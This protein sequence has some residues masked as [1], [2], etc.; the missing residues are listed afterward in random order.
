[1]KRKPSFLIVGAVKGGTTALY[2]YL[3]QHKDIFLPKLKE[4]KFF[5]TPAIDFPQNGIGDHYIDRFRITREDQYL[6]L[7]EGR[8][9][10]LIGEATPEYLYY[11]EKV[12]ESVYEYLGDIKIIISLRNPV[13]RAFSSYTNLVRDRREKLTFRQGLDQE[14][15]RLADNWDMLWAYKRAGLYSEQV[16]SFINRFSKV[17]IVKQ[18]DMFESSL[19]VVRTVL[20]FLEVDDNVDFMENQRYNPSGMPKNKLSSFVLSRSNPISPIV[21]ELAKQLIPRK[22]LERVAASSIT[23]LKID[24][25]SRDYLNSYFKEDILKLEGITGQKFD[26][27]K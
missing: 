1:M 10:N 2:H 8:E 19:N 14:E 13:D 21:R 26:W 7:F 22:V 4:P 9:E 17:L 25:E 6:K 27:L 3:N 16:K 18:E 24:E 12:A 5:S 23:K 20:R 11:H 15:I